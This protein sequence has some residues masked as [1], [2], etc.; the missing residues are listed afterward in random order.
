VFNALKGVLPCGLETGK[1]GYLILWLSSS[2]VRRRLR[3]VPWKPYQD[4]RGR[5]FVLLPEAWNLS[6]GW[7]LWRQDSFQLA[8][9]AC[10]KYFFYRWVFRQYPDRKNEQTR[11][12][13]PEKC[14]QA[15]VQIWAVLPLSV[16]YFAPEY[17]REWDMI[18]GEVFCNLT[19]I[20]IAYLGFIQLDEV[21]MYSSWCL[22]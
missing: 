22:K 9:A 17:R 11:S 12:R 6:K 5:L 10:Q 13:L 3:W 15:I 2:C 14:A 4:M 18:S 21:I 20:Q 7:R 16:C 1:Y 19:H 8:A